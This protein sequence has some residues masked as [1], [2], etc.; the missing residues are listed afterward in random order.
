M[1]YLDWLGYTFYS[2]QEYTFPNGTVI[3]INTKF[4][5]VMRDKGRVLYRVHLQTNVE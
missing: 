4:T 2:Q 3:P 1:I 5:F